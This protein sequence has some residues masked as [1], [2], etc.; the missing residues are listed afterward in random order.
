MVRPALVM[1]AALAVGI[2]AAEWLRPHPGLALVAILACA[3]WAAL[4]RGARHATLAVLMAVACLGALRYAYAQTA[5]HG[6]LSAWQGL[7]AELTGTVVTEPELLKPSGTGYIVQVETVNAVGAGGKLYVTQRGGKAPGFG[8]RVKLNGTLK[9][10]LGPRVPGGFDR[11]AYLAR[12]GVYLETTVSTAQPQ[13]PGA[14]NPLRRAAVAARIKLEG[15]LKKTLPPKEAALMAG[16]LFGTRSD[17]PDDIKEAFKS[18]GV[19]HLLAVSGGNIAMIVMPFMALLGWCGLSKRRSAALAIPLV[20]FFVFL[21]GASPS[22]LRAGLMAVLVLVGDL[23]RRERNALNTLGAAAFLLLLWAPGLVFDL[24]FQF[25]LMATLGILLFARPIERW[26]APKLQ[27]AFGEKAGGWLAAGLSV[28][29][30]AQVM[31]EP[32]SLHSFGAFSTVA[33]LANLMVLAFLEPI[34]NIGS[35]SVLIGLVVPMVAWLL[36]WIVRWGLWL[37][38]FVVKAT[39][40]VPGAYLELGQLPTVWVVTWYVCLAVVT[41]PTLRRALL[42]RSRQAARWWARSP[43]PSRRTAVAALV[44]VLATGWTWR[45]ALADPPDTLYI[46]FLDVGQ[47]DAILIRAPGGRNMLVDAGPASPPDPTKGRQGYDTGQEVVVPYAIREGVERFDYV[48]LTHP[49]QDH[50]G[51]LAAVLEAFPVGALIEPRFPHDAQGYLEG[52]A[53]AARKGIPV[54]RPTAGESFKLGRHVTLEVLH[55]SAEFITGSRSDENSNSV[56]LRLRFRNISVL[57]AGDMEDVVEDRLLAAEVDLHA[58]VLKVAHHG[59]EYSSSEAFL[60]AVRPRWA[61]ISA[62]AGNVFG[63]PHKETLERLAAQGITVY[64]TDLHGSVTLKT[65]GS[66]LSLSGIRGA[67]GDENYRPLGLLNRRWIAA[68]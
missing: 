67:P 20:I 35:V 56:V 15:V 51:G 7:K 33:P 62:G 4:A 9:A 21:T 13:G 64:R 46:T 34:V 29:F 6:N 41:A 38:V 22:V 59:S 11:A 43:R 55:P 42:D 68:W 52:V 32:I 2:G 53:V 31:V 3:V 63:H 5:G 19:F 25:S 48:V 10:P 37:L 40:A 39:S 65:D 30:A 61:V 60:R 58:D 12:Q 45:L 49:H 23:L 8:E 18:S 47:G 57:L 16:L 36:N 14:L 17:L 66:T 28:T 44:L 24:G 27:W 54:W 1:A 50:A 26:L